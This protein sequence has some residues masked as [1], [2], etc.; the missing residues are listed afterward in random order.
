MR[1]KFL[2]LGAAFCCVALAWQ[3][4]AQADGGMWTFNNFPSKQVAEKYGFDPS[5]AWLVRLAS[6]RIA[7]GCSASTIYFGRRGWS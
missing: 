6:L 4:S 2:V 1:V 5:Q 3:P 7:G